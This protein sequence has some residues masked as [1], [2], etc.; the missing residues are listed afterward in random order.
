MDYKDFVLQLDRAAGQAGFVTRVLQSPAGEAEAPFI[1]PLDQA[2]LDLLW[3]SAYQARQA[4]RASR[5]VSL[6]REPVPRVSLEEMGD[7]LFRALFRG[8][9]RSCWMRSLAEATREPSGG[10]RL[11]LQLSL[12]D[13]EIA[14]LAELPWEYLFSPEQGGFLGLQRKTP[15]LRHMRLPLPGSRPLPARPIRVL[16]VLSQPAAMPHLS[17]TE[18]AGKIAAALRELPGVEVVPLNDPTIET[19]REALLRQDFQILHFMGHGGFEERSGQG[20]LFFTGAQGETVP[21]SGSLLATHLAGMDALRLIFVNACETARSSTA[22]PFAGVATALLRAGIPA[23]IAMQRPIQDDAALE[24]S[25]TVYRRLAAGDPIDAAVTEGR[26]AIFRDSEQPEWGTPVL[27]SRAEDGRIFAAE[28]AEE[29]PRLAPPLPATASRA[30]V[31]AQRMVLSVLLAAGIGI[32]AWQ[33]PRPAKPVEDQA[34]IK[35]PIEIV[36]PEPTPSETPKPEETP[37][38]PEHSI[39]VDPPPAKPRPDPPRP[40]SSYDLLDGDSVRVSG[41]EAEVGAQFFE[42]EG[43]VLARFSITPKSSGMLQQPPVMGTGTIDFPADN[44]T[45]HLDVLSL[46]RTAKRAKVRLRFEPS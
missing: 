8:P 45:Y 10:L 31:A 40:K 26:L 20:V 43:Y 2:D 13:P 39:V 37:K 15:I 17:L 11:K 7:R 16:T 41:L 32:A 44:G 3:E 34:N 42:R 12:G 38:K 30:P 23:V 22:A 27:F 24:F 5:G 35:K 46:D 33:W 6:H 29:Q 9:V 19:L 28:P 1:N 18:E 4:A 14:G 25:R 36:H 21:V